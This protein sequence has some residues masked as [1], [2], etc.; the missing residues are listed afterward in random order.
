MR[1]L[2]LLFRENTETPFASQNEN[3]LSNM[4]SRRSFV[5][6]VSSFPFGPITWMERIPSSHISRRA[7]GSTL[8]HWFLLKLTPTPF[9]C[10]SIRHIAPHFWYADLSSSF[11]TVTTMSSRKIPSLLS[12]RTSGCLSGLW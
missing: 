4:D 10:P 7:P 8:R 11:C 1:P 9:F 6:I 3:I 5:R 12:H 2:E